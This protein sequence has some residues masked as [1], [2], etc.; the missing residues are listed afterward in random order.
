MMHIGK[1]AKNAG[2]TTRTVRYYEEMGLIQPEG[3]TPGG[4]RCYS[5]SQLVRLQMV[6]SLKEMGFEL[7]QIKSILDRQHESLT[8]GA[9]AS[10]ILQDL[11]IRLEEVKAQILHYGRMRDRL[12]QSIDSLRRCI[13][14]RQRLEERT[15]LDCHKRETER[16]KPLPFFHRLPAANGSSDTHGAK[17]KPS[18]SRPPSS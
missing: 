10:N 15:C 4:F 9:L 11:Q 18:V 16:G 6:L 5:E 3:R 14:C 17:N 7:E 2:I 1:L 13:P 8:G 12:T